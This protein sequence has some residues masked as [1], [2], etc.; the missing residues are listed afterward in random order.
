MGNKWTIKKSGTHRRKEQWEPGASS[1][2]ILTA[3]KQGDGRRDGD[4][5]KV[6]RTWR[7]IHLILYCGAGGDIR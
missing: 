4:Q 7:G 3:P 2:E 5:S 1:E 6:V